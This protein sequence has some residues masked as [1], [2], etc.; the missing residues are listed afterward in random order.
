MRVSPSV[1]C[2]RM[3][4]FLARLS[5][6]IIIIRASFH[7]LTNRKHHCRLCGRIIC[8][9]PVKNPQ[10][11]ALCSVLFV[12]DSTTRLIEEVGEGVDYGVKKRQVQSS[13]QDKGPPDDPEKFLRGVRVCR[14]CRPILL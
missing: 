2:A 3:Q 9:L 1:R 7:P 11:P 12:V 6:L 4:H 13:P 5:L 14:D 8:A 10:R